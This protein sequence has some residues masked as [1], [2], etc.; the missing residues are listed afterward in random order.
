MT[1]FA[2]RYELEHP[3]VTTTVETF[4]AS[5]RETQER[6]MVHVFCASENG[7]TT[8]SSPEEV[9]ARFHQ[10]TRAQVRIRALGVD[11]ATGQAYVVTPEIDPEYIAVWG[12]EPPGGLAPFSTAIF[13]SKITDEIA[14]PAAT[15]PDAPAVSTPMVPETPQSPVGSFSPTPPP[16]EPGSFTKEFLAL[17]SRAPGSPQS[18]SEQSAPKPQADPPK[19]GKAAAVPGEPSLTE[20]LRAVDAAS[21]HPEVSTPI[22]GGSTR[23]GILQIAPLPAPP[24]VSPPQPKPPAANGPSFTALFSSTPPAGPMPPAPPSTPTQAPPKPKVGAFTAMFG[25][26]EANPH[27]E[28]STPAP[29]PIQAVPVLPKSQPGAFTAMFGAEEAK[30]HL[31]SPPALPPPIPA[32]PAPPKPQPG[33]FTAMFGAEEA[34]AHLEP[35]PA[36]GAF[37]R[38]FEA[39]EEPSPMANRPAVAPL[40]AAAP[41]DPPHSQAPATSP[42]PPAASAPPLGPGSPAT[43]FFRGS[44]AVTASPKAPI[45]A[46]PSEYTKVV[47]FSDFVKEAPPAT[48]LP[49]ATPQ[50]RVGVPPFPQ[51]P[52]P[53]VQPPPLPA[54][55]NIP[56][57]Q[58]PVATPQY[59]PP[60]MPPQPYGVPGVPPP[61]MPP[62]HYQ[63]PAPPMLPQQYPAPPPPQKSWMPLVILF[64]G[65]TVLAL[66]VVLLFALKGH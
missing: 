32:T 66:V 65:L 14:A 13:S 48:P 60:Q 17:Q 11:A 2:S 10:L 62:M 39:K 4:A 45:A 20:I 29:P 16:R 58:P 24:T 38:M 35:K 40:G 51:V 64:L 42:M 15:P 50:P 49:S 43:R 56:T 31:E 27:L 36:P 52:P 53:S 9:L 28:P 55:P 8:Y 57:Y 61:Q 22:P 18:V 6:V 54:Y 46:G 12:A 26:E 44:D 37:T 1:Q 34:K 5:D 21:G 33:S 30:P 19:P 3:L 59:V 7:L 63:Q 25:A 47:R 23:E 41:A